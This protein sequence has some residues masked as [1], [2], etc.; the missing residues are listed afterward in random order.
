[1]GGWRL[2]TSKWCNPF[3]VKKYGRDTAI[4]MY[5]EYVRNNAALMKAPPELE[6][7][8]LGCWCKPQPCHGDVLVALLKERSKKDTAKGRR[9]E[10]TE[11]QEMKIKKRKTDVTISEK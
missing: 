3:S 1:M 10:E 4:T 11:E 7:K 9:D 2:K 8:I 5:E 6:G